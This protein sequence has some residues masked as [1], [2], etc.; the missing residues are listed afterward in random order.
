MRDCAASTR[1]RGRRGGVQVRRGHRHHDNDVHHD[2]DDVHHDDDVVHDAVVHADDVQDGDREQVRGRDQRLHHQHQVLRL[3]G[4]EVSEGH[5]QKAMALGNTDCSYYTNGH[6]LI[7]SKSL[8][9]HVLV[10]LKWAFKFPLLI[11]ETAPE[12]HGR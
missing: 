4:G 2:D 5:G 3:A 10:H 9:K 8:A 12:S 7:S 6:G 11:M 1:C